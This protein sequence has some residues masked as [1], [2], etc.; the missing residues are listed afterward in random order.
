MKHVNLQDVVEANNLI[1][2]MGGEDQL[3][4]IASAA[5]ERSLELQ[6]RVDRAI[7]YAEEAHSSSLHVKQVLRILDGSITLDDEENEVPEKEYPHL[8]QRAAHEQQALLPA[9]PPPMPQQGPS[10]LAGRSTEQRK[11][12]RQWLS[13]QGIELPLNMAVPQVYVDAFDKATDGQYRPVP[14]R[15]TYRT[16]P[17]TGTRGKLKPGHGLDGRSQ[18]ERLHLT[19]QAHRLEAEAHQLVEEAEM[20]DVQFDDEGGEGDTMVVERE[21]DLALSAQARDAV[22][23][24]DA[25]LARISEGTYGYSTLSGRPIP[26]ERLEAIPWSSVL[27]EEKVGGIGRR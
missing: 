3:P 15:A 6:H 11:V 17:Y 22:A 23:E 24:I 13:G 25:A 19:G 18:K 5:I 26:K 20:G 10:G 2:S 14:K 7:R 8:V 4:A 1:V 9:A 27:V 16:T 12:F 21:R